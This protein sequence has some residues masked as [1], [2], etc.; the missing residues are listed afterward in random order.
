MSSLNFETLDPLMSRLDGIAAGINCLA[1]NLDNREDVI[2][3]RTAL[4]FS[5][6]LMAIN[7]ELQRLLSDG[8]EASND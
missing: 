7:S 1:E 3:A 4:Y 8:K 6:D 2:G 5:Q